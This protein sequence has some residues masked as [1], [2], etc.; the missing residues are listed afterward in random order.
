MPTTVTFAD[1][2]QPGDD[3][4]EILLFCCI[5]LLLSVLAIRSGLDLNPVPPPTVLAS[6]ADD[7]E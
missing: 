2:D 6:V 3:L 7:S 1:Q 5:G 4:R